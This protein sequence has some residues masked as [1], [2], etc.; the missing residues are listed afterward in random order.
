M[1]ALRER[2]RRR[3]AAV[4]IGSY[5][6]R[7]LATRDARSPP[8]RRDDAAE[9]HADSLGTE[10]AKAIRMPLAPSTAAKTSRS[11]HDVITPAPAAANLPVQQSPLLLMIV[12]RLC[13]DSRV[14]LYAVR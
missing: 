13:H 7:F 14:A 1:Q 11:S 12:T 9:E 3:A 5:T 4:T 6:V 10:A 2:T 8:A